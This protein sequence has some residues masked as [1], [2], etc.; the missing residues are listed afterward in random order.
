MLKWLGII[1]PTLCSV[2]RTQ[3]AL[4]IENLILRQQLAVL[5]HRQALSFLKNH[6]RTSF[7]HALV[8]EMEPTKHFELDNRAWLT[9]R[10][11]F[12]PDSPYRRRD[13][14]SLHCYRPQYPGWPFV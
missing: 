9:D 4:A 7:G 13:A 10:I 12:G 14:F 6:S 1:S 2:L 8:L 3:R 11:G 5:M